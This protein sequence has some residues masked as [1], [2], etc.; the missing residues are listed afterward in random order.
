MCLLTKSL[1]IVPATRPTEREVVMSTKANERTPLEIIEQEKKA[2]LEE[3]SKSD[4]EWPPDVRAV[5]NEL[6]GRIFEVGLEVR[7]VV[8]ACGIG[9]HNVRTRFNWFVG[10]GIKELILSHRLKL[11]K[12][13][14]THDGIPIGMV[15]MA[16]GYASPGGFSATFKRWE[17]C[18]PSEYRT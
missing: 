14:L 2:Y 5:Y 13:L 10:R 16:V 15:A 3:L 17:G 9:D 8:E 18:S 11:A 7:T 1:F 12:R 4:P 6:R